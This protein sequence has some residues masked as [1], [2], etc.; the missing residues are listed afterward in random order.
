MILTEAV[1]VTFVGDAACNRTRAADRY[2][3]A[4]PAALVP[5]L[6]KAYLH[7]LKEFQLMGGRVGRTLRGRTPEGFITT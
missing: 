6:H 1:A 5:R 2:F 4:L 3:A 7:L